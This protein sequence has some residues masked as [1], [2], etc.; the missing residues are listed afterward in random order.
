MTFQGRR[1]QCRQ[2]VLVDMFNVFTL[3]L[4][5]TQDWKHN[6]RLINYLFVRDASITLSFY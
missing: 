2:K 4:L 3:K 5:G 1:C 6:F